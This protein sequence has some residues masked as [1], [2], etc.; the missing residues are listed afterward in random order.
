MTTG[1]RSVNYFVK[2]VFAMSTALELR[3][4]SPAAVCHQEY[5]GSH[6]NLTF[7]FHIISYLIH[8]NC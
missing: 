6:K 7:A 4:Q 2:S 3:Q 5:S 1:K 8:C